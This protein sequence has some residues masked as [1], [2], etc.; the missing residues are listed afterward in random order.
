MD[1]L[2]TPTGL[3]ALGAAAG[4]VL[5]LCLSAL[6]LLRVRGLRRAQT[7]VLGDRRR[8]LVAHAA[9]LSRAFGD[10]R[11]WVD[12]TMDRLDDRAAEVERRIHGC[13]AH[14]AVVR[15]DAYGEM[16][17][18]QSSS[19]ALLDSNRTGV[20]VSS[21]HHRDQARIYVKPVV[22]GEAELELSPEEADAV[23]TALGAERV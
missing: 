2:L 17:G 18:R 11:E 6:A 8:D 14:H 15:Y 13:L 3:V 16:S 22:A 4:A 23:E 19:V 1:A 9:D 12:T 21:I 20:V 7:A 5:T 10:L